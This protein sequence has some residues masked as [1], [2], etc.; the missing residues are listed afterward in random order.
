MEILL[1]YIARPGSE[2]VYRALTEQTGIA[3]WFTT[4]TIAEPVP[5]S[6]AEFRFDGGKRRIRELSPV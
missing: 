1:E 6:V 3:S 4:D 2:T 5:G